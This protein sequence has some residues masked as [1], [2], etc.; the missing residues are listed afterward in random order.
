V[1][2]LGEVAS[3]V[4]RSLRGRA[5]DAGLAEDTVLADV[6]LSSLQISELLFRI[7][8]EHDLEFDTARAARVRTLGDIVLLGAEPD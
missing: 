5:P 6:G 1:I 3:Q 7:E 8:D 2:T 4:R